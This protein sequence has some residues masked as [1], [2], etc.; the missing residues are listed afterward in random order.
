MFKI[1][2]RNEIIRN[3]HKWF[4]SDNKIKLFTLIWIFHKEYNMFQQLLQNSWKISTYNFAP[5]LYYNRRNDLYHDSFNSV[6]SVGKSSWVSRC[7]SVFFSHCVSVCTSLLTA[8]CSYSE[9]GIW[10]SLPLRDLW[11]SQPYS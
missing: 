4:H 9:C 1:V 2:F 6:L 7:V 3:D 8:S 5:K 10:V 11:S